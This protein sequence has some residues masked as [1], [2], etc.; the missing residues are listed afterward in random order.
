MDCRLL[1]MAVVKS[2]SRKFQIVLSVL[3]VILCLQVF[4]MSEFLPSIPRALQL[5]KQRRQPHPFLVKEFVEFPSSSN[6]TEEENIEKE[7]EWTLQFLDHNAIKSIDTL[8][9]SARKH[10]IT[11]G[12]NC[13]VEAKPRLC[14]SAFAEGGLNAENG[15]TCRPFDQE[16]LGDDFVKKYAQHFEEKE[17]GAGW[18]MWKPKV[19]LDTLYAV[20]EGDY[21][22]YSDAGAHFV[23]NIS[24]L[25]EFME[26]HPHFKGVLF[27]SVGLPQKVY[28]KRDAYIRMGC[29]EPKCHD[30][31]QID[32]SFGMFRRSAYSI[33]VVSEWLNASQDLQSISNAPSQLG[34]EFEDFLRHRHDQALITNVM[35]RGNFPYDTTNAYYLT[36]VIMHTRDKG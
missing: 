31:W 6:W 3:T 17:Y 16:D 10:V 21:V 35:N 2:H 25:I 14:R 24:I 26:R 15:D 18:W 30:A 13:C 23:G 20:N 27:F 34:N 8:L 36:R 11:Y 19:I 5:V 29:D 28:C 33:N 4:F 22:I 9:T 1:N 12:H 7:K 32:A